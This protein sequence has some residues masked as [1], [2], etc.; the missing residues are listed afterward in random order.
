[1]LGGGLL[2]GALIGGALADGQNDA[3]QDVRPPLALARARSFVPDLTPVSLSTRRVTKT[4]RTAATLAVETTWAA[5][6]SRR[7]RWRTDPFAPERRSARRFHSFSFLA[8]YTSR[9]SLPH[10]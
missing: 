1:M 7:R 10:L 3:Y 2:G 9:M 6:I 4:V 8:L 5:A